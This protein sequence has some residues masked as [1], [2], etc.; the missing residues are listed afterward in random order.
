MSTHKCNDC[1]DFAE[2]L[3]VKGVSDMAGGVYYEGPGICEYCMRERRERAIAD[4]ESLYSL[5]YEPI[6]KRGFL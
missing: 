1:D 4:V 2:P 3:M 6:G 5:F